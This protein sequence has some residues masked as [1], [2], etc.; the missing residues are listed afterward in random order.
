MGA[1]LLGLVGTLIVTRFVS[2]DDY[3]EVTVAAVLVMTANQL[4]TVGLGQ[5]LVSRPDAG[6]PAAFHAT[7]FHVLLGV[8][9]LAVL[10]LGGRRLGLALDV[11]GMTRFLPGLA[12]SVLFD[13]VA[14]V[15]ERI[16]VRD[17]RFGVA[18]A[19]RTAGEVAYSGVCVGLASTGWG[20]TAIVL[21]NVARSLVR[22]GIFIAAVD[23]RDW[24]E[25]CRL[26][27]RKTRE[28]LAFGLP[29]ALG[30]LCSFASRRWDNLLVSGFF[31]PGPAGM[32]NLAYNLADVPAIHV[33][34]QIGDVLLPSFA[35][36]DA[37][38][39]PAALVRSVVLLAL[40]VFPLA[41]GL[42][43]V[44]P[45]LVAAL[46]SPRWRAIGPMLVMLSVLSVTRPIG[47][48][49]ASY[50][51]ARHLPRS[52]LGLEALK[53][54]AMVLLIVTV[55]ARSP[56]WTCAAVGVAFGAHAVAS[57]WIVRRIDAVPLAPLFGNLA[58]VL[59]ACV[60][61]VAAVL[62][63]RFL[64]GR[65]GGIPPMVGLLLETLVGVLVYPPA[66]LLIAPG[67]ARDLLLRVLDALRPSLP[68]HGLL[69]AKKAP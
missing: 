33:G 11:P 28:L 10:L 60:P 63:A 46:F 52:I 14:F 16:L 47:W 44:A 55:G 64:L 19:G 27:I 1:R 62:G 21:G 43:A 50:L 22:A 37:A 26:S 18:G 57:L 54:L 59:A 40:V 15:P 51:Q 8:F 34:E 56:L 31:G 61:M 49:I 39:R 3:G 53:L 36:M 13:R 9:A 12:V 5:Y 23:R 6:R 65:V 42:G 7:T 68:S 35:R 48:T 20:A 4:S 17:L 45:T 2:P 38:R 66:A 69:P 24:L 41:V 30:A 25:P 58:R 29:I 32:Y 67:S